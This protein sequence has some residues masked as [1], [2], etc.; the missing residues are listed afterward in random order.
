VNY[1]SKCLEGV[2]KCHDG[3]ITALSISA[4][5]C[6]TGSEDFYLRVWPLDF[7]EFIIEAK[8]EGILIS[9]DISLDSL[10]VICGTSNGSLGVLDLSNHNYK[11]FLRSHTREVRVLRVHSLSNY[12]V[13]LSDDLTI[14]VW[15]MQKYEQIYEFSYPAEDM[16]LS[17]DLM[18]TVNQF[19]AGFESGVFRVFDIEKTCVI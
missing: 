7:S 13:T 19:A 12:V 8:H 9:L 2:Y 1:H 14:R 10:K 6:V 3:A 4:G 17:L 15:D 11:T 16:C 5:F 18:N